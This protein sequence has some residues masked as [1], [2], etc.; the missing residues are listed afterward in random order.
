MLNHICETELQ[1]EIG[2]NGMS[3]CQLIHN[4]FTE[5][6]VPPF[7]ELGRRPDD[8]VIVIEKGKISL[9][10]YYLKYISEPYCTEYNH[11]HLTRPEP[12][13]FLTLL[14]KSKCYSQHPSLDYLNRGI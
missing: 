6:G 13:K 5:S 1:P 7:H 9:Q 11:V 8:I 3:H 2:T 4:T 12:S 14:E 10:P